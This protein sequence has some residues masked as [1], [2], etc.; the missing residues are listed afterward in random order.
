VDTANFNVEPVT[1]I[2]ETIGTGNLADG[3]AIT[4]GPSPIILGK[5][6]DV[7]TTWDVTSSALSFHYQQCTVVQ[8]T[9]S[10]NIIKVILY[11]VRFRNISGK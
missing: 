10:I 7:T 3:F 9:V 2:G 5:I 8:G 1:M 4:V 6:A 11:Y